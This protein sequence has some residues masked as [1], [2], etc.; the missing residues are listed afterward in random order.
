MSTLERSFIIVDWYIQ[1]CA[2]QRWNE[3]FDVQEASSVWT[4]SHVVIAGQIPDRPDVQEQ[5]PMTKTNA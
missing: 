3:L 5:G 4:P 1:V 2:P